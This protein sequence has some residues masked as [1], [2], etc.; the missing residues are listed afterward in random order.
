[1]TATD[2]TKL[3][4]PHRQSGLLLPMALVQLVPS[5]PPSHHRLRYLLAST[6]VN[7]VQMRRSP[8]V[9]MDV[10]FAQSLATKLS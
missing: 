7:P 3:I 6:P 1:M 4:V 10:D 9:S 5:F 2:Y 8:K